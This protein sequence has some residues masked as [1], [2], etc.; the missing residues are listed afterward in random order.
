M[1][2]TWDKLKEETGNEVPERDEGVG[3][4]VDNSTIVQAG[5][6]GRPP[7]AGNWLSSPSR[8]A[9][10]ILGE[11]GVL[12]ETGGSPVGL[13]PLTTPLRQGHPPSPS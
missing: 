8:G 6:R 5:E 1:D 2:S 11:T 3:G 9:G 12:G 4:A 7:E 13:I 10:S